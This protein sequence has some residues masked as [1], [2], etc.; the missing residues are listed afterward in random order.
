M[1]PKISIVTTTYNGEKYIEKSIGSMLS[2]TF[3]DFEFIIRIR[4]VDKS[5]KALLNVFFFVITG[6]YY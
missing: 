5:V 4:L 3:D 1:A 6:Y 2:Q